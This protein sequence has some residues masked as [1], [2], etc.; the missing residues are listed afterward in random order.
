MT[1]GK[2]DQLFN[3]LYSWNGDKKNTSITYQGKLSKV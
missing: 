2:Q 3:G 1:D